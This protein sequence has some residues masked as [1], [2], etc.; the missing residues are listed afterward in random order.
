MGGL[1]ITNN[2]AGKEYNDHNV[3]ILGA[4]FSKDAGMPL[5][6]EFMDRMRSATTWLQL[7]GDRGRE[8]IAIRNVL[9]FRGRSKAAAEH[10][11]LNLDNVEELFS[12]AS[13]VTG[14]PGSSLAEDVNLAISAT[15]DFARNVAPSPGEYEHLHLG[16]LRARNW[17]VPPGWKRSPA[18]I[19]HTMNSLQQREWYACPPY[20]FYLGVMT[21]RFS[22]PS[23]ESLNTVITFNYDTVIEDALAELAVP[24]SYGLS[25]NAVSFHPSAR[26][27]HGSLT[28]HGMRLLKLHGSM[29]WGTFDHDSTNMMVFGS[30]GDLRQ[31]QGAQ[32]TTV[33]VPPTWHKGWD[34]RH[35][36][37][38]VW[39][40][41]VDAIGTATR[42]IIIGYSVPTTDLH[43]KYLLAA[44]L[45]RN[46][47][48]SRLFVVNPDLKE[49]KQE[50]RNRLFGSSGL[51]RRER[52]EQGI[53]EPI[54]AETKEFFETPFDASSKPYRIRIG[55]SLNPLNLRWENA[56]V[57]VFNGHNGFSA[58]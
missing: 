44:G 53:V 23:A 29:N 54:P 55:R 41:A 26:C 16:V 30:Y 5:V 31:Q 36:V 33:L 12:L 58:Q 3:Y 47:S 21:R 20:Q 11:P 51:F 9:A 4:G 24:F 14:E 28:G 17:A 48:L 22:E 15:L 13:T 8:L 6:N 50:L 52:L 18:S 56:P 37:S 34:W 35:P 45:Q 25:P 49:G 27:V 7:Q 10:I 39:D 40:A 1:P 43:F 38:A 42:I 46:I 2:Y 57:V 32:Q 19:E